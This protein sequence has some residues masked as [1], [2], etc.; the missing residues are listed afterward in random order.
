MEAMKTEKDVMEAAVDGGPFV[1]ADPVE[2][3]GETVRELGLDLAGLT[4]RDLLAADR[5]FT[6]TGNFSGVPETSKAYLALV[7]ARAARVSPDLVRSLS[8]R[9]FSR[10]TVQVQ[11]F[12]LG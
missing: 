6:A 4:G 12:L 1:L 8:G 7:A 3:E 9:D 10:L 2:F 5:E 11:A